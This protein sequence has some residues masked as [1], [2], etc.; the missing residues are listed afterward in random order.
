MQAT[1]TLLPL[2]IALLLPQALL[3]LVWLGLW[4]LR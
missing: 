1:A 2:L 3:L 4:L